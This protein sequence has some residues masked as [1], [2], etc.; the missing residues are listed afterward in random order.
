MPNLFHKVKR[1]KSAGKRRTPDNGEA[2]S[3]ALSRQFLAANRVVGTTHRFKRTLNLAGNCACDGSLITQTSGQGYF[4]FSSGTS[5]PN[6]GWITVQP[7][8]FQLPQSG[9]FT[10]LFDEFR[11]LE[12]VVKLTP[13]NTATTLLDGTSFATANNGAL[14]HSCVDYDGNASIAFSTTSDLT[15]VGAIRQYESYKM[16]PFFRTDGQSYEIKVPAPAVQ[17]DTASTGQVVH[18][19]WLNQTFAAKPHY[20]AIIFVEMF[21]GAAVPSQTFYFKG[22]VEITLEFRGEI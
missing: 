15:S 13:Y 11:M 3:R 4:T 21:A 12:F 17:V 6:Y 2:V 10:N 8:L 19:P 20:G 9:D 16:A 18:S 1:S 14:I 7:Q 22:E 5:G